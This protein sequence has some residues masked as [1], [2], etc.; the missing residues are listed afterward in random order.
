MFDAIVPYVEGSAM[1]LS[2]PVAPAAM[3]NAAMRWFIL[4]IILLADIVDLLDATITN[5]AAPSI[6]RSLGGGPALI[7]WLGSGYALAMGIL[8]VPGGRLGDKFGRRRMFLI[9]LAGFTAASV[10]VGLSPT[11]TAIIIA[12]L[13]QGAFGALL[14]PQGFSILIKTFPREEMGKVFSFFGPVM[15]TTA[16][17]GPIVAGALI[18]A[19][20]AGLGWR[21]AFLINLI[22]GVFAFTAA[23][24]ILPADPG[25]HTLRIDATGAIFLGAAMLGLLFGMVEGSSAGWPQYTMA[26]ALLGALLFGVFAWQQQ[27]AAEPLL[28]RSLLQNR[29]FTAGLIV[30]IALFAALG[31]AM[32]VIGLFVQ[33]GLGYSPLQ[34]SIAT[35]PVAIGIVVAS[36]VAHRF[37]AKLGRALLQ[38]SLIVLLLGVAGFLWLVQSQPIAVLGDSW[39]LMALPLLLI[40][41]GA[42]PAFATVFDIALGD[43]AGDEAGSASGSVAAV[44]QLASA[45]GVA[46]VT[47]VY[48]HLAAT[49]QSNATAASMLLAL[50]MLGF[51]TLLTTRMPRRA[52]A[53]G[54]D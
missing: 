46:A 31:G 51:A 7:P 23:W 26:A 25:D 37:V 45:A 12:R 39:W 42:G 13:V 10:A 54:G 20:I 36:L 11:P 22:V 41:L 33:F 29:G 34:A 14:I 5:I 17:A 15:G 48:L 35:A 49:S 16:V 1:S 6:A 53:E 8:L 28:R 43:V 40:G 21:S 18:N 30:G 44:Q 47:T 24:F 32:L 3:P 2:A 50:V 19:N 27:R 4:A 52:Q 9:G 38:I